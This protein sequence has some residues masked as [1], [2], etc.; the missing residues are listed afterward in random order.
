MLTLLGGAVLRNRGGIRVGLAVVALVAGSTW[1]V[2]YYGDMGYDRV[3][4]M[5][6][7]EGRNALE[8][9]AALAH[10]WMAIYHVTAGTAMAALLAS[11]RWQKTLMVFAA[12]VLLLGTGSLVVG[13][14]IADV[15]GQVRHREFRP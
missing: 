6:D 5:A 7:A 8:E 4:A 10:R 9:H 14:R 3:Y 12:V 1:L 11:W 13:V 2:G 15:G